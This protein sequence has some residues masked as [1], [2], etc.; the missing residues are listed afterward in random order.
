MRK[1]FQTTITDTTFTYTRK[2]AEI[3]PR[4]PALDGS[5]MPADRPHRDRPSD[6]DVVRAY[7]NLEQAEQA[8]DRSKGPDLQIRRSFITSR[9][10]SCARTDLHARL[11]LT[12][13][14]K[15]A[16]KPCCSPTNPTRTPDRS[17][18]P[19]G[20]AARSRKRRRKSDQHRAPRAQ[21][22]HAAHRALHQTGTPPAC[23]ARPHLRE[24]HPATGPPSRSARP[25]RP[26]PNR[27]RSVDTSRTPQNPRNPGNSGNRLH[28]QGE[29]RPRRAEN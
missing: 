26:R 6:G 5:Y 14:L 1:H 8:F 20:P 18:K 10:V 9:T 3:S 12:W 13:H 4:K 22:P 25:R 21:L 2:T 16:W 7:K 24:A 27:G 11:Y 28:H 23:T 17:R 15:A 19:S 29:L